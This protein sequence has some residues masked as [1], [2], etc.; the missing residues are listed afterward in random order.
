MAEFFELS[1]VIKPA[2]RERGAIEDDLEEA[3][4]EGD[5]G[6]VVGAGAAIDG[7]FC[8]LDVCVTDLEAGLRVLREVLRRY[9]V[10]ASTVIYY[11]GPELATYPVYE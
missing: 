1:V 6:E 10:P 7:S 2:V 9:E 5:L 11:H 4:Q 8:D 3:F